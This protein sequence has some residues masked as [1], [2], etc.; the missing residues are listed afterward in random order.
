MSDNA[1]HMLK[2]RNNLADDSE[3]DIVSYGCSAHY[4][5]LWQKMSVSGVKENTVQVIKFFRNGHLPA[6]WYRAAGAAPRCSLEHTFRLS[7]SFQNAVKLPNL[8]LLESKFLIQKL[9]V[10]LNI[11]NL[12]NPICYLFILK[13]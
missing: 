13:S 10:H 4:L 12:I 8:C 11:K 1:A 6:A 7:D 2:T 9:Q 5:N 3:S